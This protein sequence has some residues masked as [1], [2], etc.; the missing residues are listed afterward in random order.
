MKNL[1]FSIL[2][3]FPLIAQ[4]NCKVFVPEK[5]Y[6]VAGLGI[7]FDF[8]KLLTDKNYTEVFS[9]NEDHSWEI[10]LK[11]EEPTRNHFNYAEG[12]LILVNQDGTEK[13][14]KGSVICFT[15]NCAISDYAKS[16]KKA[17]AQLAKALPLC[18][19]SLRH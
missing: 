9:Q 19:A 16:F 6:V 17:Y 15:Q 1:I 12:S 7:Q 10:H 3:L 8:T 14:F 2:I 4:S 18:R 11:G 13:S 5:E